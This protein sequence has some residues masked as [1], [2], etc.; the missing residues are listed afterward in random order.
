MGS[1]LSNFHTQAYFLRHFSI[2]TSTSE[3]RHFRFVFLYGD[4]SV[5]YKILPRE[6]RQVSFEN[7]FLLALPSKHSEQS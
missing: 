6:D 2:R 4:I 7:L 5:Y 1:L 3:P